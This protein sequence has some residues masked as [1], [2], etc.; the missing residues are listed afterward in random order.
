[1]HT[2]LISCT[3]FTL[4]LTQDI[5]ES[6]VMIKKNIFVVVL[7]LVCTD[8]FSTLVLQIQITAKTT[9]LNQHEQFFFQLLL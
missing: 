9:K 6:M 3:K 4:K 7:T 1:M 5:L 2:K 8:F